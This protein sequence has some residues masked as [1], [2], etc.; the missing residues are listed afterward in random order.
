MAQKPSCAPLSASY[1]WASCCAYSVSVRSHATRDT[2]VALGV[3]YGDLGCHMARVLG[4][5]PGNYDAPRLSGRVADVVAS[6]AE[7]CIPSTYPQLMVIVFAKSID[8][9]LTP[10]EKVSRGSTANIISL[11]N[12]TP[13]L[14][15]PKHNRSTWEVPGSP[16]WI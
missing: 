6:P 12:A 9:F 14:P 2:E 10:A 15:V 5:C 4:F 11:R 13:S 8:T 1:C 16:T 7:T 3:P